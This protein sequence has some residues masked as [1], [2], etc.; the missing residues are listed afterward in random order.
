MLNGPATSPR[1]EPDGRPAWQLLAG[2][3]AGIAVMVM[4]A[5]LFGFGE[6]IALAYFVGATS[7]VD[8]YFTVIGITF[9]LYVMIDDIVA[10]VF[11]TQYVRRLES[12]GPEVSRA[13]LRRTMGLCGVALFLLV[14][15]LE[16]RPESVLSW[17]APGFGAERL[18]T[19]TR[20]LRLAAPGG[21][22]LGLS[23]ITYCMLNAHG[24][25]VW[26]AFSGAVSKGMVV[27]GIVCLVPLFGVAGAAIGLVA[28]AAIQL[29]MQLWAAR[30]AA[31]R[32]LGARPATDSSRAATRT[33]GLMVP[34]AIGTL[35]A[36]LGAF[37]DNAWGSKLPPGTLAALA[38]ARRLIDM[39]ILLVPA[40]LGI[41]VFPRLAMLAARGASREMI[42]F[43]G[44]LVEFC[45][46]LFLPLTIFMT[47]L[48][49]PIVGL[50][51]R[52]GAFDQTAVAV[53]ASA[54]FFFS[55]GLVAYAVEIP[56]LRAYYATLD[57]WTPMLV[58]IVF[59]AFNVSVT[60][61][62]IPILGLIAIPLALSLQKTLKVATLMVLLRRRYAAV[63][64]VG[65]A[66]RVLR[67]GGSALLFGAG[68]LLAR[69]LVPRDW[70]RTFLGSAATLLLAGL[71]AAIL[72]LAALR[73]TGILGRTWLE[74]FRL[75]FRR[76]TGLTS[77][78]REPVPADE[79]E[80]ATHGS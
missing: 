27:L 50:V 74:D 16:L 22:L 24:S 21:L 26:P 32:A 31:S 48:S 69:H 5:K 62:F 76:P 64:P 42:A 39:P 3:T 61:T 54:L 45:L 14:V 4:L 19:G 20:L 49:G 63:W 36:Q 79:S 30:R 70:S 55:L 53:T 66:E 2:P 52:R 28:G 56:L 73:A 40:A 57:M 47:V 11:L 6:K 67:I 9:F 13:L 29:G 7:A 65:L 77:D 46:A 78:G 33:V 8:A 34:L 35:V 38:Y 23:A 60:I 17:V 15:G 68:C 59:V 18:A 80:D 12:G 25:F 10:P 75:L 1:R 72:Y 37:V 58:G 41:V 51:F 44:R 71:P 43:L